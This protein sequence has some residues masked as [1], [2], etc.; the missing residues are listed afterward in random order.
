MICLFQVASDEESDTQIDT[1]SE[2]AEESVPKE[3]P[4]IVIDESLDPPLEDFPVDISKNTT[5][6]GAAINNST[7][8]KEEVKY[9]EKGRWTHRDA[10]SSTP[11]KAYLNQKVDLGNDLSDDENWLNDADEK[12]ASLTNLNEVS[13]PNPHTEHLKR[14]LQRTESSEAIAAQRNLQLRRQYLLGNTSN[15]PRKSVSTADL[16]NRFKSFMD[17]ISETQKMLNPAPQPSPA[18]QVFMNKSP[19][20]SNPPVL[21]P[22]AP[23]LPERSISLP[24]GEDSG[25]TTVA[26]NTLNNIT[27][28]L[29]NLTNQVTSTSDSSSKTI[30]TPNQ[31]K[32][33]V[34]Q[35][36]DEESS[37]NSKSE[38]K[39]EDLG[40]LYS[41]PVPPSLQKQSDSIKNSI[42]KNHESGNK[43]TGSNSSSICSGS[44]YDNVHKE[45]FE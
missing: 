37:E 36:L 13:K 10:V 24:Q 31:S 7:T 1:D 35:P 11:L 21:S 2:F 42:L 14:L 25:S 29:S 6:T 33:I 9:G 8:N 19:I 30:E 20:N 26:N 3:I 22:S 27:A 28:N 23:H 38:E 18:M 45:D 12:S 32:A 43:N 15:I 17:K 41:F 16:G 39:S 5:N 44:D 40:K 34:S 4:T